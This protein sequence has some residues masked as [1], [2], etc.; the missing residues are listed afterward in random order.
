MLKAWSAEG[1]LTSDKKTVFEKLIEFI[2]ENNS[3]KI[4]LIN[5]IPTNFEINGL[6]HGKF[7]YNIK[8]LYGNKCIDNI[9]IRGFV[10]DIAAFILNYK[11][12]NRF[13][14]LNFEIDKE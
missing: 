11:L 3:L 4:S 10:Q 7:K 1:E 14:R 8:V 12:L 13:K 6:E 2:Y 9:S 5:T